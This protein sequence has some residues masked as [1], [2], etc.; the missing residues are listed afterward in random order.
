MYGLRK[1]HKEGRLPG[2]Q[3]AK[4]D[5]LI[6]A[7]VQVQQLL[8]RCRTLPLLPARQAL[9]Q[10]SRETALLPVQA[11]HLPRACLF[12]GSFFRFGRSEVGRVLGAGFTT[13]NAC[14]PLLLFEIHEIFLPDCKPP[15]ILLF[16]SI[17]VISADACTSRG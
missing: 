13:C 3:V 8:W 1:V 2:W 12:F 16:T 9:V 5:K 17:G 10:W 11:R 15:Q 6:F 14:P 4:L 7:C